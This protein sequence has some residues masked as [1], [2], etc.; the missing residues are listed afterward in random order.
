MERFQKPQKR[1]CLPRV[2]ELHQLQHITGRRRDGCN[3]L[4]LR[5][6]DR[7]DAAHRDQQYQRFDVQLLDIYGRRPP[8]TEAIVLG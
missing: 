5:D 6:V 4:S 1:A 7:D 2:L 8:S 3:E